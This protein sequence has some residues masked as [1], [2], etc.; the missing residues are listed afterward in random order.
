MKLNWLGCLI[1]FFTGV[2]TGMFVLSAIE[3]EKTC[4]VYSGIG[5]AA[6]LLWL[7][8]KFPQIGGR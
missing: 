3:R 1:I 5:I 7:I 2:N 4:M 8:L 6:G